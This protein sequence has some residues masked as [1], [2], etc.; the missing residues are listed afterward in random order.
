MAGCFAQSFRWSHK[1][2]LEEYIFLTKWQQFLFVLCIK[3][4]ADLLFE[5]W[6]VHAYLRILAIQPNHVSNIASG[7]GF[8]FI[9]CIYHEVYWWLLMDNVFVI[10]HREFSSIFPQSKKAKLPLGIISLMLQLCPQLFRVFSL[11]CFGAWGRGSLI[12]DF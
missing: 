5:T 6:H 8:I 2:L 9:A 12:F 7:M 10:V 1:T 3:Q 11:N 4:W